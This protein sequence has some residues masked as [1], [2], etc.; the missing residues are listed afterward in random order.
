MYNYWV[1]ISK[2]SLLENL[3]V[4]VIIPC[5]QSELTLSNL[6]IEINKDLKRN[7]FVKDY[8]IIL[9]LDGPIDGTKKIAEQLAEYYTK[10]RVIELTKNFGQHSAILAGIYFAK[11]DLISTLDDDGQHKPESI[12]LLLNHLD[13]DVDIIYGYSEIEVHS[14]W[15]VF[16]SRLLKLMLFRILG[17]KH[18]KKISALRLFRKSLLLDIDLRYISIGFIDVVLHW[19]TDK[20]ISIPVPMMKRN[21]RNSNYSFRLLTSLALRMIINYSLRPLRFIF[22]LGSIFFILSLILFTSYFLQYPQGENY[23]SRFNSTEVMLVFFSSLQLIVLGIIGEYIGSLH[24]KN[25]RRPNFLV[26]V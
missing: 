20:I 21:F 1:D 10:V 17:V 22:L 9:V 24:Q 3:A 4:S 13:S 25:S 8:E 6:V 23:I 15:R 19:N 11:F 5:F 2:Q 14:I 12:S 26:K 16:S 7:K 18:S